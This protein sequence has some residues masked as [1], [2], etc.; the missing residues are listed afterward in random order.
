ML[1]EITAVKEIAKAN[2]TALYQD[3]AQPSIR[4]VGKALAQ[5]TSLFVTPVGRIAEIFEKNLHKYIDRLEVFEEKELVSPD[6]RILVPIL[7]RLRYTD[8]EMVSDYYA[9]I[10]ATAS[11]VEH[12]K[13]VSIAFIEI[14]NR[15]C[16]DELKILEFLNSSENNLLLTQDNDTKILKS[17]LGILP[18]IDVNINQKSGGYIIGIKNLSYL[19]EKIKFNSPENINMYL[20]NMIAL[21]LLLKPAMIRVHGEDVYNFLKKSI[22]IK[23][24]EEQLTEGQTIGYSEARIETTEL[25]TQLLQVASKYEK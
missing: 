16:A 6:P 14:L 25:G 2:S 3:A 5:W 10:L 15:L 20:D 23:K 8:D 24:L 19:S 11:T 21:G 12:A 13:K 4:V 22:L 18:V 1:P 7:E 9:Q 17:F